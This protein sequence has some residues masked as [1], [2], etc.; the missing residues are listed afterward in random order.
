MRF[1]FFALRHFTVGK[2]QTSYHNVR[3]RPHL[4]NRFSSTVELILRQKQLRVLRCLAQ[5]RDNM[6]AFRRMRL[7]RFKRKYLSALGRVL[8][9]KRKLRFLRYRIQ[10][11]LMA[12]CF[13]ALVTYWQ[14][15]M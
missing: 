10:R 8:V 11:K 7:F 13:G 4:A 9:E 12:T 3:I 6:Q 15:R 2:E 14:G 5:N 1:H